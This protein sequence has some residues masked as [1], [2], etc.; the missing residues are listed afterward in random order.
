MQKYCKPSG[1]VLC[2]LL[3]SPDHSLSDPHAC[4]SPCP[5]ISS[6]GPNCCS[7]AMLSKDGNRKQ[8]LLGFNVEWLIWLPDRSEL[9]KRAIGSFRLICC[10]YPGL[11][12]PQK[13]LGCVLL[14]NQDSALQK[15]R[16]P[17]FHGKSMRCPEP[18]LWV[19]N[20][21]SSSLVKRAAEERRGFA[22]SPRL[23]IESRF[24]A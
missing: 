10:C 15:V 16:S 18:L 19:K 8:N 9:I 23:F 14:S 24:C 22:A 11:G 4:F 17:P 20:C 5:R 2:M 7:E 3:Q 12:Q 21:S 6:A 1:Y 13:F